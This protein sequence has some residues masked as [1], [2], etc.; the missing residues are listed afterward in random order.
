M[1]DVLPGDGA[2]DTLPGSSFRALRRSVPLL[3]FAAFCMWLATLVGEQGMWLHYRDRSQWSPLGA[4]VLA[5][6]LMGCSIVALLNPSIRRKRILFTL[7]TSFAFITLGL[8]CSF[9]YWYSWETDVMELAGEKGG[10]HR[11]ETTSDPKRT[12]FGFV[13]QGVL[14][15]SEGTRIVVRLYWQS[16]DECM[17]S[18]ACFSAY[19]KPRIP[20]GNEAG[21][22]A[23]RNGLCGSITVYSPHDFA[24][25][26]SLRGYAGPLRGAVK[27]AILAYDGDGA[28]LLCGV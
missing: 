5:C 6:I 23:H 8:I 2:K 17:P 4:S 24:W 12:D 3:L 7:V 14:V 26:S 21:R 11:F 22:Y 16:E 20:G 15:T 27:E 19:G 13:S 9:L 1:S 10:L 18:G 25:A 28:A